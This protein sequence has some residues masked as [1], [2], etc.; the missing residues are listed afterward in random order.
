MAQFISGALAMGYWTVGLIFFKSWFRTRDRLFAAFAAAFWLLA[1]V[2]LSL[3]V[4]SDMVEHTPYL[5][6]VRLLAYLLILAAIVDKNRPRRNPISTKP[7]A[8]APDGAPV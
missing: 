1:V 3:V 6:G 8:A 7:A 4:L 2:R 5:Y